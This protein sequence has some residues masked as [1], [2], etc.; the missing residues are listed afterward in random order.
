MCCSLW[1]V[2]WRFTY[3]VQYVQILYEAE[4]NNTSSNSSI[5]LSFPFFLLKFWGVVVFPPFLPFF[6]LEF[7]LSLPFGDTKDFF[8]AMIYLQ[9][10]DSRSVKLDKPFK[11][12]KLLH[13]SLRPPFYH[14]Y[15][16]CSNSEQRL[17]HRFSDFI[18]QYYGDVTSISQSELRFGRGKSEHARKF[19]FLTCVIHMK[20]KRIE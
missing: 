1:L 20:K 11:S 8:L 2:W 5:S 13:W 15:R 7:V 4:I 19:V 18:G 6:C 9:S 10:Y 14:V 12:V 3:L 16:A 17:H